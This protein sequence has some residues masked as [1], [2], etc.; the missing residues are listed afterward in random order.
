MEIP[1]YCNTLQ[2]TAK[3]HVLF[4]G[5]T[6]LFPDTGSILKELLVHEFAHDSQGSFAEKQ[7]LFYCDTRP[8]SGTGGCVDGVSHQHSAR[9]HRQFGKQFVGCLRGEPSESALAENEPQGRAN[10][11]M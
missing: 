3:I 5:D 9:V 8:F 10:H 6:H 7:G 2:H 11:E 4:Y 1:D